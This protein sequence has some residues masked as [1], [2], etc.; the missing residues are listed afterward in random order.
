[1]ILKGSQRGGAIQLAR[2]LLNDVDNDHIELHELR[3]FI[4]DDLPGAMKEAEAIS[5]GTKCQQFLFSLSLSPPPGEIVPVE[6]FERAIA[7]IEAK[8]GLDG[9][10]RAVIFHEKEGRRHAH[11]VWSRIDAELMKAINLSH[12]K[13]KL[14]DISRQL[15]LEHG[16]T[17]PRGLEES[18]KRDPLNYDHAEGQQ[19]K[20]VKQDPKELKALFRRCWERSDSKAAFAR[21]L[22]EQGFIL[23]KGDRR[24]FVAVDRH[25]EVYSISRWIGEKAKAVRAR[26]GEADDLPR[27]DEA[28]ALFEV[29]LSDETRHKAETGDAD[30]ERKLAAF[31]AKRD[32]LVDCQRRARREL[33]AAQAARRIETTESFQTDARAGW[34]RIWNKVTGQHKKRLQ[35]CAAA[36][37]ALA[38]QDITERQQ[39]IA[40]QLKERRAL[41]HEMRR[42]RLHRSI[43]TQSLG[44]SLGDDLQNV[45]L[46]SDRPLPAIDPRRPLF[47]EDE[48]DADDSRDIRR[49]PER[50]IEVLSR[51]RD[52]FTRNDIVRELSKHIDDPLKLRLAIDHVLQ[53]KEL[54][55][56][57]QEPQ[58]RFTAR[59][60]RAAEETLS[61]AVDSM[62]ATHKHAVATRTIAAA[63]KEQND[64]LE[65][66]VGAR[67]SNEQ[68]QAIRHVLGPE[69]ISAVVGLAGAGKSTALA[70]ART[71]WER[72]GYQ[73]LGAA[74]SGPSL[75]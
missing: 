55:E 1:M 63:I 37:E 44:R 59:S 31:A 61:A 73:V 60:F 8:I 23:A 16:W 11:C 67:L 34:R 57:E 24:G 49:R 36:H 25:G 9:Q 14:R 21:A 35:E 20:R 51:T 30:H 45:E 22:K 70:A 18:V 48:S 39:M 42:L 64:I 13:L 12:F 5:L 10:P 52:T 69:Q 29:E 15:F 66:R 47:I 19:A 32:A 58:P 43:E 28:L 50:I 74:L 3:G 27:V 68:E 54:I 40:A 46:D 65:K 33:G 17:M 62:A 72:H 6:E 7:E 71:A 75:R 41:G 2:H 53:S 56:V 38:E 26:L 4:A